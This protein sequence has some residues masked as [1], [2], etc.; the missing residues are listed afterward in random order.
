[1][2]AIQVNRIRVRRQNLAQWLYICSDISFKK[3]QSILKRWTEGSLIKGTV[4]IET[5]INYIF[6]ER[7]YVTI[8]DKEFILDSY[9]RINLK[10]SS[11]I[12]DLEKNI[13]SI[14]ISSI[15]TNVKELFSL[16][17]YYRSRT[18]KQKF[19][20]LLKRNQLRIDSKKYERL[21]KLETIDQNNFTIIKSQKRYLAERSQVFLYKYLIRIP[22][23]IYG[24][25]TEY[26]I[27]LGDH[28]TTNYETKDFIPTKGWFLS[29]S[30]N[31]IKLGRYITDQ[32]SLDNS[33][34]HSHISTVKFTESSGYCTNGRAF[35]EIPKTEILN[36]INTP[37]VS[38][39]KSDFEFELC[40]LNFC[41]QIIEY[42]KQE[43]ISGIPYMKIAQVKK[44]ILEKYLIK[45]NLYITGHIDPLNHT[46]FV[47]YIFDK[48]T[49]QDL[50]NKKIIAY[51]VIKKSYVLTADYTAQILKD[52]YLL[53]YLIS[54]NN[55]VI[56]LIDSYTADSPN[57]S[58]IL[59]SEEELKR[60]TINYQRINI[61]N[62]K[63]LIDILKNSKDFVVKVRENIRNVIGYTQDTIYISN[64]ED[65]IVSPKDLI[66]TELTVDNIEIYGHLNLL[67]NTLNN[68]IREIN[69]KSTIEQSE[70]RT[71]EI[72]LI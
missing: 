23:N 36:Y 53:N 48:F 71:E 27:L 21:K 26:K 7:G 37:S 24:I 41:Y 51:N 9:S 40:L 28:I 57:P 20:E 8:M 16:S 43:S 55:L 64:V 25:Q 13:I 34:T 1:M 5:N 15:Y 52:N 33:Y 47:N 44:K 50:V 63:K 72:T 22:N 66:R 42:I 54:N 39:I 60:L 69:E 14:K 29:I 45:N 3:L 19:V 2:D 17:M 62:Y 58:H 38:N 11:H 6:F 49:I 65:T 67:Q 35:L 4:M 61:K 32:S 70:N 68:K 18:S 56:K 59:S 31:T 12:A 46:N 10:N 30:T